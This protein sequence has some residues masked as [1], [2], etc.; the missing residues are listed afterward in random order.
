MQILFRAVVS[1]SCLLMCR[2]S[3]AQ[4]PLRVLTYNIHVC[5]GLDQK[6]DVPRIAEAIRNLEPDVVFL[7]EVDFNTK[8][9]EGVDQTNELARL[10]GLQGKFSPAIPLQGGHYGQAVLS[11][12]PLKNSIIHKLDGEPGAEQRIAAE[13]EIDVEGQR[14]IIA[15]VHLV[16][17]ND[18]SR[19]KQAHQLKTIFGGR[20]HPVIIGGDFNAKPES[21]VMDLFRQGWTGV[22]SVQG[23]SFPA[24]KPRIRLDYV[25]IN[26]SDKLSIKEQKIIN[27]PV[28]SDHLPV[29]S[30]IDLRAK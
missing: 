15:T 18:E 13:H 1:L 29:L 2:L 8:R 14:V 11:R 9:T 5:R 17:D 10:T 22:D 24:N 23:P 27:E 20:K 3:D 12:F 21:P 16:H 30:V 25:L 26:D 7:Q 28:A 6:L 4:I 19:L